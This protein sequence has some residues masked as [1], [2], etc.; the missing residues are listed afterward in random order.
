MEEQNRERRALP[1]CAEV[2]TA[3]TV[4]RFERPEHLELHGATVLRAPR[5]YPA[6]GPLLPARSTLGLVIA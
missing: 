5:L 6:S 4:E 2:E 3:V 1:R